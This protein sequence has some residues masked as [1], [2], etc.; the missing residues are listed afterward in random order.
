MDRIVKGLLLI[1]SFSPCF[2]GKIFKRIEKI[3][4][5]EIQARFLFHLTT[6][7]VKD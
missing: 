3:V 1:L 6:Y 2:I 4:P 7:E 5:V